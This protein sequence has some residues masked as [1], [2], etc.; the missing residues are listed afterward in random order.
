MRLL[1]LLF[2]I[3]SAISLL[4]RGLDAG[5]LNVVS[6]GFWLPVF[7]FSEAIAAVSPHDQDRSIFDLARYASDSHKEIYR[8]TPKKVQL[9][10]SFGFGCTFL[11]VLYECFDRA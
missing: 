1:V 4:C 10:A 8:V 2:L 5:V 3:A 11:L 7:Y 9:L 6:L